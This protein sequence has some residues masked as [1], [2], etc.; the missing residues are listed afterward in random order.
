MD[1]KGRSI[2]RPFCVLGGQFNSLRSETQASG[3]IDPV[4]VNRLHLLLAEITGSVPINLLQGLI[5]SKLALE[6]RSASIHPYPD[7]PKLGGLMSD[8]QNVGI[9]FRRAA[10]LLTEFSAE[11]HLLTCP[12]SYQPNSI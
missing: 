2:G 3:V 5:V 4:P 11:P 10:A 7:Y 6:R 1:T 8:G 12:S 9:F